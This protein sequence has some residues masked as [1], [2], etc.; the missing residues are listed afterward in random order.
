MFRQRKRQ[1]GIRAPIS[2]GNSEIRHASNAR[3]DSQGETKV[4]SDQIW[5][6]CLDKCQI[7]TDIVPQGVRIVNRPAFGKGVD[8]LSAGDRPQRA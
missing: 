2:I 6:Y 8:E 7:L 3:A 1:P 5:F 4:T